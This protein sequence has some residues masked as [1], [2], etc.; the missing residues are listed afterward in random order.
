[1]STKPAGTNARLI[2]DG[3]TFELQS[4]SYGYTAKEVATDLERL[5][6]PYLSRQVAVPM[7]EIESADLKSALNEATF[8][9][10]ALSEALAEA[11]DAAATGDARAVLRLLADLLRAKGVAT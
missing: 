2:V 3:R 4:Q 1:M 10:R 8:L 5:T 7:L 6:S 9:R 11:E